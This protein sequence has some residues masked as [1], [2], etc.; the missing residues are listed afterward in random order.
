M[1]LKGNNWNLFF[2]SN[3]DISTNCSS[4][5]GITDNLLLTSATFVNPHIIEQYG[6]SCVISCAPE[7]PNPP[8]LRENAVYYKMDTLDV[9][10]ADIFQY[11]DSTA[12]LIDQV[13]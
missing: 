4:V 10:L 3:L 13:C 12:N 6:V 7:L 1:H 11:F 2:R 9:G 5:S 8:L